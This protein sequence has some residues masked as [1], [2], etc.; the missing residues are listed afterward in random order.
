MFVRK[1]PRN[2]VKI[3]KGIAQNK[4]DA[5]ENKSETKATAPEEESSNENKSLREELSRVKALLVLSQT[6]GDYTA[7][8]KKIIS[9]IKSEKINQNNDMPVITRSMFMKK[10][11]VSSRFIDS[12]IRDLIEKKEISREEKNYTKKIKTFSYMMIQ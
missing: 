8:E 7:N 11:K 5:T 12:S 10:Y 6:T 3:Q 9:A 2:E 4:N 1:Q